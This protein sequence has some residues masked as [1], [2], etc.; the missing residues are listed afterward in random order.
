MM[1]GA[2]RQS[3]VAIAAA[4]GQR[5][6]VSRNDLFVSE[7]SQQDM[8]EQGI[9]RKIWQITVFSIGGDAQHPPSWMR[10]EDVTDW[11]GAFE[12]KQA[13]DRA[14]LEEVPS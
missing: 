12:L 10:N 1:D 7:C 4:A 6:A 11:Y 5:R 14:L 13:L 3:A 9:M 8:A 2:R